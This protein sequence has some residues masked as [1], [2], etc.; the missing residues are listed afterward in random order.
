[1]SLIIHT[2]TKTGIAAYKVDIDAETKFS[3]PIPE[4]THE[5]AI[6][7]TFSEDGKKFAYLTKEQAVVIDI[8]TSTVDAT[9]DVKDGRNLSLSPHGT[10]LFIPFYY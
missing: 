6:D 8:E 10:F 7:F 2:L 5:G 1:M 9:Y 3:E 4:Y